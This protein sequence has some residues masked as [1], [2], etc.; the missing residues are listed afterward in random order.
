MQM[1]VISLYSNFNVILETS[2]IFPTHAIVIPHA[3]FIILL[4]AIFLII[5]LYAGNHINFTCSDIPVI[6]LLSFQCF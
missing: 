4:L 5:M 3:D 6:N 1:N 2:N